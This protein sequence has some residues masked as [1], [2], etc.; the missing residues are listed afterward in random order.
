MI[1]QLDYCRFMYY[2]VKNLHH[3]GANETSRQKVGLVIFKHL[4]RLIKL[5]ADSKKN[6]FGFMNWES[7]RKTSRYQATLETVT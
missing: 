1:N 3:F 7:F 6:W 2:L 5:L 4:I